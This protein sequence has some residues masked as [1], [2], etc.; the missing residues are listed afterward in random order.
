M[1]HQPPW[2]SRLARCEHP[3]V[4]LLLFS[5]VT[6][7]MPLPS[8]AAEASTTAE[9]PPSAAGPLTPVRREPPAATAQSAPA[10]KQAPAAKKPTIT[11]P[12]PASMSS[13]EVT[14][15]A[16]QPNVGKPQTEQAQQ[17]T[18]PVAVPKTAKP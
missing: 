6:L 16:P 5:A 12:P 18:P 8:R 1:P 9:T 15:S 17:A 11:M 7:L 3:A 14:P 2:R 10:S 13:T 4:L